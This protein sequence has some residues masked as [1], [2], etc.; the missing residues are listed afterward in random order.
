[1]ENEDSSRSPPI[2]CN[3]KT[4]SCKCSD[5]CVCE[6][7]ENSDCKCKS[8]EN[9]KE[10]S[11][12][13]SRDSAYNGGVSSL[14]ESRSPTPDQKKGDACRCKSKEREL[15]D[16]STEDTEVIL[17]AKQRLFNKENPVTRTDST[18]D[19]KDERKVKV[20][21]KRSGRANSPKYMKGFRNQRDDSDTSMEDMK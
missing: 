3:M 21:A 13:S 17:P 8:L 10:Q 7:N 18:E 1:M 4:S 2:D 16:G 9:G 6:R 14:P 12:T 20:K 19:E 15:Y 11:Q 5:M